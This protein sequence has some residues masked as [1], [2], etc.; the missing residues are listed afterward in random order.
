MSIMYLYNAVR[1]E[2]NNFDSIRFD[3]Q[4]II[5]FSIQLNAVCDAQ[6]PTHNRYNN[7]QQKWKDS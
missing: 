4:V 7:T 2:D 1:F 5:D 6:V 3:S